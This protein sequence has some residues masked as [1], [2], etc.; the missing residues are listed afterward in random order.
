[1]NWLDCTSMTT[2]LTSIA[3]VAGVETLQLQRAI[4]D[5]DESRFDDRSEDAYVRMPR[6]VLST[7]GCDLDS[8]HIDGALYFHGTRVLDPEAIRREGLL[9]LDRMIE[10]IWEMLFGLTRDVCD[11]AE[12]SAFRADIEKGGGDHDGWLYRTKTR[13]TASSF[14]PFAVLVRDTL[15]HSDDVGNHDYLDCP[16]IVQD[17]ARAFYRSFG[18]DVESRFRAT[19]HAVIVTIRSTAVWVGSLRAALWYA[20]DMLRDQAITSNANEGFDSHGQVV[21]PADVIGLEVV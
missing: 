11:Q 16:E 3:T 10:Q 17:I 12:W 9:P 21:S 5:F 14:G 4:D 20:F 1:L 13:R 7:L 6:E 15:L 19:S 8:V 18:V 2:T